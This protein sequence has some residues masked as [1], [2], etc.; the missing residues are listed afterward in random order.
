M[1]LRYIFTERSRS[2]IFVLY[3]KALIKKHHYY[4]FKVLSILSIQC[5]LLIIEEMFAGSTYPVTLHVRVSR[6]QDGN[7][8]KES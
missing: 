7:I 8:E 3:D 6:T 5:D 1:Y 4:N 2:N